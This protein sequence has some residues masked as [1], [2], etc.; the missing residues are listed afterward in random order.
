MWPL[1][2]TVKNT[3]ALDIIKNELFIKANDMFIG[4]TEDNKENGLGEV[5][6]YPPIEKADMAKL[7]QHFKSFQDGALNP[8]KLQ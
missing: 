8:K 6:S 5:E 1:P 4:V 7:T 2:G 3:M